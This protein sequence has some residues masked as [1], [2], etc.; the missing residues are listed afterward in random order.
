MSASSGW[1]QI[2]SAPSGRLTTNAT[3]RASGAMTIGV[4]D[5]GRVASD[6]RQPFGGGIEYLSV[7]TA[8]IGFEYKGVADT[9]AA[10]ATAANDA[11]T[12][13]A[14]RVQLRDGVTFSATAL[15]SP[16]GDVSASSA[17]ARSPAD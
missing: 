2:M 16:D 8:A 14:R 13:H 9:R 10:T 15:A 5:P 3:L 4:G 17:N 7:T 6:R 11:A 1:I 12:V